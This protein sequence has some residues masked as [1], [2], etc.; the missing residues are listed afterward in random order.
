MA[1]DDD[2]CHRSRVKKLGE[3]PYLAPVVGVLDRQL[4]YGVPEVVF[5]VV[6]MSSRIKESMVTHG[7]DRF[8]PQGCVIPYVLYVYACIEYG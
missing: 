5:C 2:G 3:F 6:G 8:R 1:F 4:A 7:L